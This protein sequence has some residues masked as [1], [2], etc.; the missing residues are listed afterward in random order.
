MDKQFLHKLCGKLQDSALR[1]LLCILLDRGDLYDEL[2]T[3][4]YRVI[5]ENRA[6]RDGLTVEH[7]EEEAE[8]LSAPYALRPDELANIEA[9]QWTRIHAAKSEEELFRLAWY[10]E[11]HD[12]ARVRDEVEGKGPP[13]N[14]PLYQQLF[15]F[16]QENRRLLTAFAE[17]NHWPIPEP[18]VFEIRR[19]TTLLSAG[20]R[21]SI[22]LNVMRKVL[23]PAGFRRGNNATYLRRQDRQIHLVNIQPNKCGGTFTVNLGFHYAFLRPAH[24][25]R[26]ILLVD[27]SEVDCTMRARIGFFLPAGKDVWFEYGNDPA[28]LA[29]SLENLARESLAILDRYRE[30]WKD[31]MTLATECTN[32]SFSYEPWHPWCDLCVAAIQI[33]AGKQLDLARETLQGYVDDTWLERRQ[34]ADDLRNELDG[35][36]QGPSYQAPPDED[37]IE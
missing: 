24:R 33:R 8:K 18:S 30:R 32:K 5:T 26:R 13:E 9:S 28:A 3:T 31:P 19:P 4:I 2:K 21:R 35:S 10:S 25:L 1:K 11:V 17:A 12:W 22:R 14:K 23:F 6:R 29:T 7:I 20:K 34:Y 36:R 15:D 37:W 27:M 16:L